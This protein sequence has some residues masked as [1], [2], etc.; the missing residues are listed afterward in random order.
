MAFTYGTEIQDRVAYAVL[1][2]SYTNLQAWQKAALDNTSTTPTGGAAKTVLVRCQQ[3]F[4]WLNQTASTTLPDAAEQYFVAAL[5]LEFAKALGKEDAYKRFAPGVE[6]AWDIAVQQFSRYGVTDAESDSTTLT[7]QTIRYDVINWLSR[8]KPMVM[9]PVDDID[10]AAQWVIN[11]IWNST[12]WTFRRQPV[13][14]TINTDS[15][16]TVSGSHVPDAFTVRA[17]Y[18]SG[19]TVGAY[20][21]PIKYAGA[22]QMSALLASAASATNTGSPRFFRLNRTAGGT[23]TWQFFPT[24]DQ[25]YTAYGEIVV[26]GPGI[27]SSVSDTT[28]FDKFPAEFRP[29]IKDMVRAK[30]AAG[31]GAPEAEQMWANATD[32]VEGLLKTF[33]DLGDVNSGVSV[34]DIYQDVVAQRGWDDVGGGAVL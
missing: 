5:N 10:K 32:A 6:D 3:L 1:N 2:Q 12:N 15:T 24:P 34:V 29:V 7:R 11:R 17:M 23:I 30:I 18:L 28:P 33:D 13:T 26:S 9:V 20:A 16:V 8:R 19:G 14:F 22:D 25:Q 21:G 4:Q 27:P 31:I